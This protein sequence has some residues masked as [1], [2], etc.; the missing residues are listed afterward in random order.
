MMRPIAVCAALAAAATSSA[1]CAENGDE[2]L[3]ILQNQF[4]GEGCEISGEEDT[5]VQDDGTLDLIGRSGYLF[6]PLVKNT[7]PGE[8]G[9]EAQR[10][11]FITGARVDIRFADVTLFSEAELQQYQDAGLTRFEVPLAGS[12]S[13]NGG[14]LALSFNI[15]QAAFARVLSDKVTG[16]REALVLADVRVLGTLGGGDI[17]S[18]KFT[19]AVNVCSGCLITSFGACTQFPAGV[20]PR[21]GNPCNPFQDSPVDCCTLADGATEVCPAPVGG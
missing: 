3:L 8:T 9:T 20:M 15:I 19:F 18:Q 10:R 5:L 21:T 6:T 17:E 16:D 1:G 11:V 12:V 13:P 7:A 2:V 4:P 14:T